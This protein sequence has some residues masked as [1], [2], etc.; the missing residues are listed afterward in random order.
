MI[1]PSQFFFL[2]NYTLL[3][4]TP[5][6]RIQDHHYPL[7]QQAHQKTTQIKLVFLL[8]NFELIKEIKSIS[9]KIT[10]VLLI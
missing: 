2:K 3:L 10:T 5:H 9:Y 7:N 6:F 1:D 4:T 8:D